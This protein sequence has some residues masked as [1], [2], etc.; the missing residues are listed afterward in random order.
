VL[1][2]KVKITTDITSTEAGKEMMVALH[3]QIP[4]SI[5]ALKKSIFLLTIVE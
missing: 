5:R 3:D 4:Y 1:K 2:G